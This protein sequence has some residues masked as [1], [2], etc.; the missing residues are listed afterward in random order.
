MECTILA[1]IRIG[2]SAI[3]L[4]NKRHLHWK[5]VESITTMNDGTGDA[6][7]AHNLFL[8]RDHQD[9]EHLV[10]KQKT[11]SILASPQNARKK[12]F[13]KLDLGRLEANPPRR[14][15]TFFK[16]VKLREVLFSS[17]RNQALGMEGAEN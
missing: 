12:R 8:K 10:H 9:T 2:S 4:Q 14:G 11:A 1:H 6:V 3:S 16:P 13:T 17:V 5:E 7:A 15:P